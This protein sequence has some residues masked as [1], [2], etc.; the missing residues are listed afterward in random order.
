MSEIPSPKPSVVERLERALEPHFS[1]EDVNDGEH[2]EAARTAFR[3]IATILREMPE[4]L[5]ERSANAGMH[6]LD[7]KFMV[8]SV[9]DYLDEQA[10]KS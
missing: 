8:R 2:K 10:A 9:A 5:V 3:N 6:S 7:A 4:E 1:W